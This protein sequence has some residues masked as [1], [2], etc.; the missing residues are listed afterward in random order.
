[1]TWEV[2]GMEIQKVLTFSLVL[3]SRISLLTS[4]ASS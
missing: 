2:N 4:G 3:T 1:M